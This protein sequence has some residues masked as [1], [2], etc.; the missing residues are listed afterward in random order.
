M[1]LRHRT[2]TD[3]ATGWR[4]PTRCLKLQVIFRKRA[5][6]HRALLRKMTYEHKVCYGSSAPLNVHSISWA[7]FG[8]CL[9][10]EFNWL[11]WYGVATISRLPQ[12]IGLFC[13]RNL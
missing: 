2:E 13:K 7:V 11:V 8:F 3:L 5:A 4:R 9:I 1:H 12:M 6:N 10:Y